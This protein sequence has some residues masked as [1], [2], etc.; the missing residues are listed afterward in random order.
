MLPHSVWNSLNTA[1]DPAPV[2]PP[3]PTHSSYHWT[4]E[5]SVS[6]IWT[7]EFWLLKSHCRLVAIGLI[8]LTVAPFA[9]GS[10]NPILDATL[11]AAILIHS[12]VG[13]QYVGYHRGVRETCR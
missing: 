8:P 7:P 3:S 4:F 2:P 12:H 5:R 13:F 11:A 10:L 9:A 1:N 6:E